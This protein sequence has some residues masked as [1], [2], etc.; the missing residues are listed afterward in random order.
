M[1]RYLQRAKVILCTL[2]ASCATAV[3]APEQNNVVSEE[4]RRALTLDDFNDIP[5]TAATRDQISHLFG[6]EPAECRALDS[7]KARIGVAVDREVPVVLAVLP[8]SPASQVGIR[9]TDKFVAVNGRATP[10]TATFLS[11]IEELAEE[12]KSLKVTTT[13][14]TIEIFPVRPV[15]RRCTWTDSGKT[16]DCVFSDGFALECIKNAGPPLGPRLESPLFPPPAVP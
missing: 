9:L 10:T 8:G 5:H 14:A 12:G 6:L 3:A 11:I 15:L 16:M 4:E 1:H 7:E 13:R 2:A